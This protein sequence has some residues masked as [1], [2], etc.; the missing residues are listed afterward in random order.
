[1]RISHVLAK[2][3]NDVESN[4]EI[5]I[6]SEQEYLLSL[7]IQ[8]AQKEMEDNTSTADEISSAVEVLSSIS[9]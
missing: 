2:M 3:L 7:E 4:E 9:F 6:N 5:G 8:D 1:M